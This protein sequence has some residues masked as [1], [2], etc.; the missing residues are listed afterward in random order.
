MDTVH[1]ITELDTTERFSLSYLASWVPFLS[2]PSLLFVTEG[3]LVT[4]SCLTLCDP[5]D[6][7]AHPSPL[8]MGFFR[9]EYWSG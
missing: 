5:M 3:V 8:S 7:I 1:G 4:Q 9:Q 2:L 6:C